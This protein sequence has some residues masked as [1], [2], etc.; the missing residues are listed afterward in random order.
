IITKDEY[1]VYDKYMSVVGK[2]Y[3]KNIK[4]IPVYSELYYSKLG[5]IKIVFYWTGGFHNMV[6]L[7]PRNNKKNIIKRKYTLHLFFPWL[8]YRNFI[9]TNNCLIFVFSSIIMTATVINNTF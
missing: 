8:F 3:F 4:D 5:N 7:T 9:H 2:Y 6:Y 1:T